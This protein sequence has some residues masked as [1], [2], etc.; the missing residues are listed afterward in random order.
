MRKFPLFKPLKI[1]GTLIEQPWKTHTD[2]SVC[3]LTFLLEIWG[4]ALFDLPFYTF[5]Y[6]EFL[7]ACSCVTI[8]NF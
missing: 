7:K 8:I 2:F 6:S 4:V 5:V 1:Q 3:A